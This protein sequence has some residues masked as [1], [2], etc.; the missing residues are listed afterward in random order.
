MNMIPVIRIETPT[1]VGPWC[2][3]LG[4][5]SGGAGTSWCENPQAIHPH[6]QS[7]LREHS[8]MRFGF[9]NWEQMFRYMTSNPRFDSYWQERVLAQLGRM[10]DCNLNIYVFGLPGFDSLIGDATQCI[11]DYRQA[12]RL[13]ELD[14]TGP[15]ITNLVYN[16]K[17]L[18]AEVEF[19]E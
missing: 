11:F 7:Y 4:D 17:P 15:F 8:T 3:K 19:A 14:P 1:G 12:E 10:R 2:N 16:F 13:K 6:A 18:L 5:W 9:M